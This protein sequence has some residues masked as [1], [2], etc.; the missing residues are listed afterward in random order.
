VLVVK[1]G[2]EHNRTLDGNAHGINS[3]TRYRIDRDAATGRWAM[4]TAQQDVRH[5]RDLDVDGDGKADNDAVAA[6]VWDLD[7]RNPLSMVAPW[8]DTSIGTQRFTGGIAVYQANAESTS[9]S[10]DGMND[11]EEGPANQPRRNW[12]MH[13]AII[14]VFSPF[15]LCAALVWQKPDFINGGATDRVSFDDTCAIRLWPGRYFMG[16]DAMRLLVRNGDQFYLSEHSCRAIG[17]HVVHPTRTRWTRYHPQA[18]YDI[19]LDPARMKFEEVKF[20][21]VTAIGWYVAKDRMVS[22]YFGCKWEAFEADAIVTGPSR[23]SRMLRMLPLQGPDVPPVYL[24]TCEVPYELWRRIHR[25]VRAPAHA[26]LPGFNFDAQGDMGSMDYT[27]R[28]DP[29][30]AW[31]DSQNQPVTDIPFHDMIAW[32]NALSVYESRTPCY[33]EDPQFQTVFREVLQ[34]PAAGPA[35]PMPKI[36]VK[37]DADGFRLPTPAEWSL[38]GGGNQP[39]PTRAT[40]AVGQGS[41]NAKGI[42]D[43]AGN[44]WEQVWTFGD[45]LDLA[46]FRELTVVGG[47]FLSPANPQSLSANPYGDEPFQGRF[48]IGLRV[49]RRDTGLAAPPTGTAGAVPTWTIRHGEKTAPVAARQFRSPVREPI[50]PTVAIPGRNYALGTHEVTFA[51]YRAVHDWA[52]AHGYEFDYGGEM[53]SMAYWGF[54]DDWAPGVRTAEEPVTGVSHSDALVWLNALSELE[55]RTP[56][57]YADPECRQVLRRMVHYRPDMTPPPPPVVEDDHALSELS[58]GPGLERLSTPFFVRAEADGYRL[59]V[60]EE[61]RHA[62]FAGSKGKFPWGD[63]PAEGREHTWLADWSGFQTHPVGRKQPNAFGLFDVIGNVSELPQDATGG[64]EGHLG[65][66]AFR[67]G[68]SFLDVVDRFDA[69]LRLPR[70]A[71]KNAPSQSR[72]LPYPDIGFRVLRQSGAR[73]MASEPA[74]KAPAKQAKRTAEKRGTSPGSE[75]VRVPRAGD[76]STTA[77]GPTGGFDPLQGRVHRGNLYRTGEHRTSGVPQF[78]GRL[79]SFRTGGP[80]RSSPVVVDGTVYVGSHDGH[81]YAIDAA[82]GRQKWS[83]AAGGIVSGSALVA[84]GVVYIASETGRFFALRATDGSLVWQAE[85]GGKPAGS[86]AIIGDQVYLGGG[87][88]RGGSTVLSMTT[89]PMIAFAAAT[90]AP[91]WEG[92][93][94]PQGYAAVATDG[95]R[96]YAGLNGSDYAAFAVDGGQMQWS[97]RGHQRRQFMSLTVVDGSV[98]VP[99]TVGGLVARLEARTGREEWINA[100]NEHN[101]KYQMNNGGVYGH[102]MFTDVA[103]AGGFVY[104]GFN[105]GQFIAFEADTGR[106]AWVFRCGQPLQS[107]P[108]VAGGLVYFG[109]W[110]GQLYALDARTGDL[111]WKEV[112]GD[113]ILSSPWPG[114]GV[115]FVGCDDG[116]VHALR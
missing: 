42:H 77:V 83:H 55:G 23:P 46:Q 8:Y 26:G 54:G 74:H 72:G 86:A 43:L 10:E 108:S 34:S 22:G 30:H 79:W 50:I 88:M 33:Y 103:V 28:V 115:I 105:D 64:P 92:A 71:P 97:Y 37:W 4:R 31:T 24:G 7:R 41:A 57:Y 14:D 35:R 51:Q 49:V 73:V 93:A 25:L 67:L 11:A 84:G 15:R 59:P 32:C 65:H 58:R 16:I 69:V 18:P 98:Y 114:N 113:R 9:L 116:S 110:D 62:A 39:A 27:V 102:E 20:D 13:R 3:Y 101:L 106:K 78:T 2:M 95:E 61:F 44:V 75:P 68:G 100:A 70:L 104:G 107:S 109:G 17:L 40:H 91:R 56:I 52:V 82:T 66:Y 47:S 99:I 87:A 112:L 21:D 6:H 38:G 76:A 85:T 29:T 36:H 90:G 5:F 53:G 60:H 48:D 45:V 12:A 81:V 94:G 1:Q 89:R 63:D 111:R 96:I 19:W 80:V